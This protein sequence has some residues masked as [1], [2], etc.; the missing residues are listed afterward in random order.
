MLGTGAKATPGGKAGPRYGPASYPKV[1]SKTTP[2]EFMLIL[3]SGM[4]PVGPTPAPTPA[5]GMED[6]GA[7]AP[8]L[9]AGADVGEPL[10]G[11]RLALRARSCRIWMPFFVARMPLGLKAW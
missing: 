1:F 10:L 4:T 9:A 6:R 5:D 11:A 2:P 7:P 8:P 3:A